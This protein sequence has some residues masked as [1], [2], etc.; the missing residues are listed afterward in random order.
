M[1]A[2]SLLL[3]PDARLT[4]PHCAREF[5]LEEG[6][7]R[8]ALESAEAASAKA[9]DELRQR[10]RAAAERRAEQ[11]AN[12]RTQALRQQ[13]AADAAR[14]EQQRLQELELLKRDL[15]DRNTLVAQ[16]RQE[17]LQLREQR[18]QLQDE[19]AAHEL[20][21]RKRVDAGLAARE[22][23]VRAQEQ[24]RAALERSELQKK[25]ADTR[26]QLDETQRK[27]AQGSQQLQGEVLELAIEEGLARVFPL[28]VIEEVKKGVRG[29]DV[30]QRVAARNGQA[31]G[32]IL[33]ESKRAKDYSAQ[34]LAKLKDDMRIAGA[35]LGVLV[36]MPA[37]VPRDWPAGQ[38]F[39]LVDGVWV[40]VWPVALQ[41]GEV[42]RSALLDVAKQ[43]VV[44]AGKNEKMEA[45]YDYVT[46][47]QFAQKVRAVYDVF[48]KMRDEL[49]SEKN[50]AM[51]RWSRREKQLQGG[52]AALLGIGGEIQG[53]ASEELRMLELEPER[54]PEQGGHPDG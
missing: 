9:M 11:A 35:D 14:A 4:C 32:I 34:W 51:Q 20:E 44:S 46:S 10:E 13:L 26:A 1:N 48:A 36:T 2:P 21:V 15:A 41:L 25:L 42:L 30:I 8:H 38:Q 18:Q 24:E 23:A 27:L 7:A 40:V 16:L 45:V 47:P 3:P 31:A 5:S 29:G 43:R 54:P 12:E 53:L 37:A 17:Q 50:Q 6:F 52:M 33:W 22:Q 19:R 28:D 39:A 49:E